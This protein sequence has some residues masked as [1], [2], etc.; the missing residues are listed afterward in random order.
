MEQRQFLQQMVL[1]KMDTTCKNHESTHRPPFTKINSKLIRDTNVKQK[2]VKLIGNN[3]GKNLGDFGYGD[4]FLDII[5]WVLSMK[6][7]IDNLVFI[8]IKTSAL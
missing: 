2:A 6:K 5:P 8:K 7:V 3:L 4:D 1:E